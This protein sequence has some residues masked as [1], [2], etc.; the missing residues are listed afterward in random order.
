MF[1]DESEQLFNGLIELIEKWKPKKFS[2]E[3]EYQVDIYNYLKDLQDRG[4]IKEQRLIRREGGANRVDIIVDKVGIEL[5]K[6]LKTQP[7]VDRA[8][9]QITR[10][11]REFNYMI[12]VLVGENKRQSI[13]L[14]KHAL[15]DL[16]NDKEIFVEQKRIK[17][18]DIN[19]K[20]NNKQEETLEP[21]AWNIDT[22]LP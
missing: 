17:I 11:I 10:M 22:S 2:S 16:I 12:V 1:Y 14:F 21:L 7:S 18:I 4:R 5:K 3:S 6:D 20:G 9:A 15:K 13:D 8:V 19:S